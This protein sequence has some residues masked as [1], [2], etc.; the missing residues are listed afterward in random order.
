MDPSD[1]SLQ[2]KEGSSGWRS[3]VR[4]GRNMTVVE[5]EAPPGETIEEH[6]HP[7]EQLFYV[8][9]GEIEVTIDGKTTLAKPGMYILIPPDALHSARV[10][11][12]LALLDVSAPVRPDHG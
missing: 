12:A 1:A 3:R 7:E 9:A 11:S 8:Q 5:W 6:R 2:R 10:V 4:H